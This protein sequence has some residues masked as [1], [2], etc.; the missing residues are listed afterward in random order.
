M[1]KDKATIQTSIKPL[2]TLH[3]KILNLAISVVFSPSQYEEK[4][5]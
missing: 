5:Q 4:Q 2:P 1:L 3:Q